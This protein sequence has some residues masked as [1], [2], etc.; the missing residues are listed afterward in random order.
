MGVFPKKLWL[1]VF[2]SSL[3]VSFLLLF[4]Q[5]PS[6]RSGD[7]SLVRLDMVKRETLSTLVFSSLYTKSSEEPK[8]L[9]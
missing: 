9:E 6:S 8:T 2:C 5:L 7:F 4:S 1:L 3:A